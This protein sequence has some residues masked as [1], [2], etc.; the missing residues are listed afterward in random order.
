MRLFAEVKAAMVNVAAA[1]AALDRQRCPVCDAGLTVTG[2]PRL[3]G[4]GVSDASPVMSCRVHRF[5]ETATALIEGVSVSPSGE[6][7]PGASTSARVVLWHKD[8][9]A[10]AARR[11]RWEPLT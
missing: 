5:W 7:T 10:A 6:R 8:R 9:R 11:W 3:A 4:A 1:V 2:L